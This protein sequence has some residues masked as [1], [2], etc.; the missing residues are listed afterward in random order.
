MYVHISF[1]NVAFSQCKTTLSV[2]EVNLVTRV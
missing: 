1:Y 2:F